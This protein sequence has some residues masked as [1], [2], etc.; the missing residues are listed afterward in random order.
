MTKEHLSYFDDPHGR[1]WNLEVETLS[2]KYESDRL[3]PY[4]NDPDPEMRG[5][6]YRL[7]WDSKRENTIALHIDRKDEQGKWRREYYIDQ[8]HG[9]ENMG[10][11]ESYNS[12]KELEQSLQAGRDIK[13]AERF[14][15]YLAVRIAVSK[16][17][18]EQPDRNITPEIGESY[19]NRY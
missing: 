4:P 14:A 11:T 19:F 17:D 13:A 16:I 1:I 10:S 12:R 9:W 6:H 18:R 3:Y 5:V 2:D 8:G 15:Q 7:C